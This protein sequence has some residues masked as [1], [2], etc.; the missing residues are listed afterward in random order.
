MEG[1]VGRG[2]GEGREGGVVEEGEMSALEAE[3]EAL[4]D[5]VQV[6]RKRKY[7]VF[8]AWRSACGVRTVLCY[9]GS[10]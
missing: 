8:L 6:S 5:Y 10:S 1:G 2:R 4:V 7:A 9:A 3:K